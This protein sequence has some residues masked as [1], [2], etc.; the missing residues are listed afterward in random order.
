[1]PRRTYPDA[2]RW[3]LYVLL[4]IGLVAAL[5]VIGL[6]IALFMVS[7]PGP[8]VPRRQGMLN[9]PAVP[10]QGARSLLRSVADVDLGVWLDQIRHRVRPMCASVSPEKISTSRPVGR[11]RALRP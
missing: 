8:P 10:V 5:L 2:N 4:A 6:T 9:A 3:L 11:P 1:M 7:A